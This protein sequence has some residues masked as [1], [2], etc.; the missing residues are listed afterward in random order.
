MGVQHQWDSL[1]IENQ[2]YWKRAEVP[3]T[4][5]KKQEMEKKY[6]KRLKFLPKSL[7]RQ[8]SIASQRTASPPT[9]RRI[10]IS[11][12]P[13]DLLDILVLLLTLYFV[14]IPNMNYI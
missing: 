7:S 6:N 3:K 13:L 4:G 2:G 12:H 10:P 5:D 11:Q 1:A 8:L 14:L 9:T